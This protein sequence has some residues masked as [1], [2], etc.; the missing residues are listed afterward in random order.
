M[1]KTRDFFKKI[2]DI[3]GTFHTKMGTIKERNGMDLTEAE[4]IKER[5]RNIQKNCTKKVLMT[6]IT[7]MVWSLTYSQHIL[8]CK[9]SGPYEASLWTKLVEAMEFSWAVSNPKRWCCESAAFNKPANLENSSGCGTGKNQF[10]FQSQGKA[11]TKIAQTTT[12]LHSSH[13]LAN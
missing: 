11:M 4:D 10:S 7:T 6:Q 1:G 8:K 12:W 2:R 3:K 13:M 9:V 5:W